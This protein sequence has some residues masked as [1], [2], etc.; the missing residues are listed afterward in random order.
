MKVQVEV[1]RNLYLFKNEDGYANECIISAHGTYRSDTRVFQHVGKTLK[2]YCGHGETV[3]DI[4]NVAEFRRNPPAVVE[5]IP[6]QETPSSMNYVL[7]KYQESGSG[8]TGELAGIIGETY[9]SLVKIK[10]PTCDI[11]TIRNRKFFGVV[12]LSD[13]LEQIHAVHPYAAY[14]CLFCRE[15]K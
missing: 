5:T 15:L 14:R 4:A 11:V 6:N 7:T 1:G 12:T 9:E 10:Y 8:E 13:V 2:F 3:D